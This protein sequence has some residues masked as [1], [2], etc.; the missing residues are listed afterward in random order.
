MAL[1]DR[2]TS[3]RRSNRNFAVYD[4]ATG[5]ELINVHLQSFLP[6]SNGDPRVLFD[7]YSGR[8]I[9]LVTDFNDGANIYLAVSLTSDPTGSWVKTSFKTAQGSDAGCWPDY[10]T[11]GVDAD[12]IYTT[13]YMVGCGMTVF[14]IEKAPLLT[15]TPHL[16][17]IT[18]FRGFSFEGAIQ[19]AH[20]FG[21][22][23]GEYFVSVS[24]NNRLKIRRVD[25][26][27]SAPTL[28]EIGLI[29]V[30]YF[31]TP[32]NAA[33]LG[34]G[35]R[36]DTVGTRLMMAVYRDGSVWTAHTVSGGAGGRGSL[37]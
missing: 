2:P 26:P 27:L 29:S 24:G 17:H 34:S 4:K 25:G 8:W 13:A 1:S 7:Q 22:A 36:L 15:T 30:P 23:P 9:V 5:A 37:V 10:P 16:G 35:T 20:T 18:A 32:S 28:T 3:S 12:G 33:A 14:A 21:S 6:D 11:L 19:P 31:G